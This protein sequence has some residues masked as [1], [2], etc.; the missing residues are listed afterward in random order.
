M[1]EPKAVTKSVFVLCSVGLV[2][3]FVFYGPLMAMLG[4]K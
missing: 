2:A 4:S 3:A 1:D